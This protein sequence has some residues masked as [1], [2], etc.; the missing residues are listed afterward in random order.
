MNV[1]NIT[2]YLF[3][4]LFTLCFSLFFIPSLSHAALPDCDGTIEGH[5]MQDD[6]DNKLKFCDG[7]DWV[8][9]GLD[10]GA[11]A[12]SKW[13]RDEDSG[14]INYDL[15]NVGIDETDPTSQMYIRGTIKVDGMINS[16][17][18]IVGN[19]GLVL[20]ALVADEECIGYDDYGNLKF[21]AAK[22]KIEVCAGYNWIDSAG[23][24]W[25]DLLFG[26][27]QVLELSDPNAAARFGGNMSASGN[28]VAITASIEASG[29][30]DRGAVYIY[31]R[32]S[33]GIFSQDQRITAPDAMDNDQFGKGVLMHNN[34]L[35]VS[36]LR[37]NAETP[38]VPAIYVY[39]FN[40][41]SWAFS[42]KILSP[43]THSTSQFGINT[44]TSTIV[45]SANNQLIVSDRNYDNYTGIL[46]VYKLSN[47]M[48][49]L[50]T[51]LQGDDVIAGS[52]FGNA[53]AI[54][55][56]IIAVGARDDTQS[57]ENGAVYIFQ[58]QAENWVQ[59]QKIYPNTSETLAYFGS[60]VGLHKNLLIVGAVLEDMNYTDQG[61]GYIYYWDGEKYDFQQKFTHNETNPVYVNAFRGAKFLDSE[62]AI[63][64][65]TGGDNDRFGRAYIATREG[66]NWSV[67]KEIWGKSQGHAGFSE[68]IIS[69]GDHFLIGAPLSAASA[70][71]VFI[72]SK[73]GANANPWDNALFNPDQEQK[74]IGSTV[75]AGDNFGG[76]NPSSAITF[77]RDDLFITAAPYETGG[78]VYIFKKTAGTWAEISRTVGADLFGAAIASDNNRVI[79]GQG[80]GEKAH[81]YT[82]SGDGISLEQTIEPPAA[83]AEFG[84]SVDVSGNHVVVGSFYDATNGTNAGAI[85]TFYLKNDTW[86]LSKKII[87][88]EVVTE[89]RFGQ[90]LQMENDMMAASAAKHSNGGQVYIFNRIGNM[91]SES[92]ILEGSDTAPGD[93]FGAAIALHGQTLVIG[94]HQHN[95]NS[96][97]VY[98]FRLENGS[99]TEIQT[100]TSPMGTTADLFG[101]R[102]AMYGD[103]L[104]ISADG[105]DTHFSNS[106]AAHI[107]IRKPNGLFEYQNSL[108]A[109]DP[110][111][112][113]GYTS[114]LS[115]YKN[116]IAV[117]AND[118]DDAG[119]DAGAVYIY[120]NQ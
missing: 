60:S 74:I 57:P 45:M 16:N 79:I 93:S 116:H 22:N 12:S 4:G 20:N 61:A 95:S 97:K 112:N 11:G 88:S 94:A 41:T 63:F 24:E 31:S 6:A 23:P 14:E 26:E 114:G 21:N 89:D 52:V 67:K 80:N 118:D 120:S 48:W 36:A 104:V 37:S 9:L 30:I 72:Y 66:S 5:V 92:Q 46:Y 53:L 49:S 8:M 15:N 40:G 42:Q 71:R 81:I 99:W 90:N 18:T 78:V 56:N 33:D 73:F 119:T 101:R 70:G 103:T 17:E 113:H 64:G 47:G 27:V 91:W 86:L 28:K 13:T 32:D 69:M 7:S 51:T 59:I 50:Q 43:N 106:G 107:Y 84:R 115:L 100:M 39:R 111:I 82:L 105:D 29:G 98:V 3:L 34:W 83:S 2:T 65:R 85:H 54:Y 35:F 58:K 87:G 68:A 108:H 109:S 102:L 62:T 1:K 96:G 25:G 55:E 44:E 117:T 38:V 110:A 77:L 76:E 75:S 10:E 19:K